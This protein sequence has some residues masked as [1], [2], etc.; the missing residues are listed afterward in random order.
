MASNYVSRLRQITSSKSALSACTSAADLLGESIVHIPEMSILELKQFCKSVLVFRRAFS[1]LRLNPQ[2]FRLVNRKLASVV[3][4][5]PSFCHDVVS[6]FG[7]I[8]QLDRRGAPPYLRP[9]TVDLLASRLIV[10]MSAMDKCEILSVFARVNLKPGFSITENDCLALKTASPESSNGR[11]CGAILASA[12][13]DLP[14]TSILALVPNRVCGLTTMELSNVLYAITLSHD[15]SFCGLFEQILHLL[16]RKKN[17]ISVSS[18]NQIAVAVY[19]RNSG[20]FAQECIDKCVADKVNNVTMSKAQT[21]VRRSL[22]TLGIDEMFTEEFPQGPFR[23]D[24]AIPKLRVAIEI[25]GPYHYYHGS[26]VATAKTRMKRRLLT[27][28]KIAEI[29]YKQLKEANDKVKLVE[30]T[31]RELV[32]CTNK[33]NNNRDKIH[34]TL[35]K[36]LQN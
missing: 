18:M 3:D 35:K 15:D 34:T 26:T 31:V 12:K 22:E 20:A 33:A 19:G 16:E 9:E 8:S 2:I 17:Q 11:I 10:Q 7:S 21:I 6:V 14:I 27:E 30:H 24:F 23:L 28:W 1:K 32:G 29:D 36:I 25:N 4:M 5:E 13:L